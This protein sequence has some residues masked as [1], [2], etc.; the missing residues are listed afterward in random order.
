MYV[1]KLY[2]CMYIYIYMSLI[3]ICIC[4]YMCVNVYV[5]IYMYVCTI[6]WS[7]GSGSTHVLPV[8]LPMVHFS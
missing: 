4:I 1:N 5:C 8:D 3:C 2:V 7:I 6:A